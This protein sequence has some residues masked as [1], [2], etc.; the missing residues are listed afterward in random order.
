[1]AQGIGLAIRAV[2]PVTR[3]TGRFVYETWARSQIRGQ[4]EPGAQFIGLITVQGTGNVHIGEGTRL[5]RRAFLETQGDGII[6]IGRDCT[7]NDGVTIVSYSSVT[8]GDHALI[9]EYASIRDANHGTK[10]G[11]PMRWQ[12]HET[13]PISVGNDAWVARGVCVLKGVTIGDGAIVGANSVVTKSVEPM[14]IAVG[15]PARSV[16][17]RES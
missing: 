9:G 10:P 13:A 3:R 5:G 4:V 2:E 11:E 1:L 8:I 16:G 15:A 7:I 6:R 12:A 14:A 17:A